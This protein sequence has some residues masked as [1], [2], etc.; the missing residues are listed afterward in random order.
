MWPDSCVVT[1]IPRYVCQ[2]PVSTQG[3]AAHTEHA[4]A[5]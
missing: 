3:E 2:K 1:L 4:V 5:F